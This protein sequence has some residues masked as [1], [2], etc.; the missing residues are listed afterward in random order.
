MGSVIASGIFRVPSVVAKVLPNGVLML[1]TW[2]I[3]GV[4]ALTGGAIF[5]ELAARRPRDGG[6]YA[7]LREA[8]HPAFAFMFGWGVLLVT[9]SGGLATAAVTFGGYVAPWIAIGLPEHQMEKLLAAG[10]IAFFTAVNALGVRQGANTQNVLTILKIVAIG[11]FI[12]VGFLAPHAP[13]AL[14]A[15]PA[16]RGG[17]VFAAMS[18]ALVPVLFAYTGWQAPSYLSGE[19]KDP[20]T[21]LPRGLLVGMIAVVGL[22]LAVNAACIY[23]LGVRGLAASD[24]PASA[25]AR[26]AFG[27]PG[28]WVMTAV[29]AIST[30][31]FLSN[32][33]LSQPRIYFQMAADGTFFKQLAWVHPRTHAPVVAIVAQGIAAAIVA[34]SGTYDQIINYG[35]SVTFFFYGFSSLALVVFRNRDAHDPA[36]SKPFFTMPLHPWSTWLFLAISW[37]VVVDVFVQSPIA[38]VIAF[39]IL[40]SGLPV[41]AIFERRRV[42]PAAA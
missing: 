9:G 12:A 26:A 19:M 27:A 39:G 29:V 15:L 7:Y 28:A 2:A 4:I 24:A 40:A 25:I 11:G 30:L 34:L 32:R 41:Y 18:F 38:T 35:V 14:G 33:M 1:V 31:G 36:A 8:F 21:T 42:K 20:Q 22:Y 37:G 3:G 10:S 6:F 17:S 13:S 23:A 5:A 16:F